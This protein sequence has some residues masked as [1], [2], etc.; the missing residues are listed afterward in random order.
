M[1]FILYI[2]LCIS[3]GLLGKQRAFGFW[4]FLILSLFIS[5]IAGFIILLITKPRQL[6]GTG[7]K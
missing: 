2:L 5:P 7:K 4:G 6:P 1:I 3:V